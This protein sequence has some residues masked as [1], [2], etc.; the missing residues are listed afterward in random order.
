PAGRWSGWAARR[1]NR[2]RRA[3]DA[4]A[5]AHRSLRCRSASAEYARFY[6]RPRPARGR[7]R[8]TRGSLAALAHVSDRVMSVSTNT[9]RVRLTAASTVIAP[10][11]MLRR[12]LDQHN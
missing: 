5:A 10:Q 4:D 6:S 3:P 11:R 8:G 7:L 12:H 9:E 2:Y 1:P